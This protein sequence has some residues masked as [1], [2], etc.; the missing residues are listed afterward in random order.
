MIARERCRGSDVADSV[1]GSGT[2]RESLGPRAGGDSSAR[3]VVLAVVGLVAALAV[4]LS[5]A[6]LVPGAVLA[7]RLPGAASA[8]SGGSFTQ[9]FVAQIDGRLRL[10]AGGLLLLAAGLFLCRMAFADLVWS[11]FSGFAWPRWP[12][13]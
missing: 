8:T 6:S 10:A 9:E 13:R 7:G 11:L 4:G 1:K 3:V 12:S 2:P 5:A